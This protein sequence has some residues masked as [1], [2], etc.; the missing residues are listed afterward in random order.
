MS[1]KADREKWKLEAA[2]TLTDPR[3]LELIADVEKAD[4]AFSEAE[5]CRTWWRAAVES[6]KKLRKLFD[7]VYRHYEGLDDAIRDALD[8]L[9]GW[10]SDTLTET[11][12]MKAAEAVLNNALEEHGSQLDRPKLPEV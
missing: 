10:C 8:P 12:R 6:H 11:E 5:R 2:G 4:E 9:T 7:E 3:V 1:T